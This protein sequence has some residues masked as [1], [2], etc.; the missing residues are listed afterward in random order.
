VVSRGLNA[1]P[2]SPADGERYLVGPSPA[3]AWSGQA[4]KVAA[5]QDGAWTFLSPREGWIAWIG[6]EDRLVF[7]DGTAWRENAGDLQVSALTAV[8]LTAGV[9]NYLVLDSIK[10]TAGDPSG[11]EG[12][13]VINTNDNAVRL[14]ADGAWRTLASW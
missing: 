5:W 11:Q 4:G 7:H 3:G 12:M 2:G 13:L 1:A 8:R 10:S 6:A 9:G 14:Y